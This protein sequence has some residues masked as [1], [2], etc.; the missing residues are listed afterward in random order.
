VAEPRLAARSKTAGRRRLPMKLVSMVFIFAGVI[1][2]QSA[3]SRR[4]IPTI[5]KSANGA[6][7]SIVMSDNDGHALSQGSG[8]LVSKDGRI[9]TNYHVIETGS[10]ALIKLPNGA[11]FLVDGV[12]ALDKSRDVAVIKARGEDFHTVPLGNS[13][14]LQVG[15]EV[16]AIGSPLSLEST[17]SNGI[18]SGLRTVEEEGGKFLQIT[19]PISPGSSG[20]P[21]FNMAGEVVGI[22]T[23]HVRSGENLNFAIPINDVKPLLLNKYSKVRPLPNEP[24]PQVSETTSPQAAAQERP[25]SSATGQFG[26]IVHNQTANMSAEFG[27]IINDVGGVVS[28]CMFVQRPLFGSGPLTGIADSS[29]VF[30]TVSSAVGKITFVGKRQGTEIDGTYTVER[31]GSPDQHGNF[32]LQLAKTEGLPS[33]FNPA[34]CP[35][36]AEIHK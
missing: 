36:D 9:V 26:G 24:E 23:L 17:V 18:V 29:R 5:A 2:A 32:S 4:D 28:G 13:D 12:L 35:T 15:E 14:Q 16:V 21:L 20:G 19:A 33:N 6:V 25:T 27:I 1:A 11:F 10:S 3:P 7:V 8:F 30:F 34:N 31:S 22:T